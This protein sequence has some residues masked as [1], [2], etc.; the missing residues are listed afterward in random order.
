MTAELLEPEA[1]IW[2]DPTIVDL[3]TSNLICLSSVTSPE[4]GIAI[5][6][7]GGLLSE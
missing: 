4:I 6:I 7:E 3:M 5:L 2:N 1:W